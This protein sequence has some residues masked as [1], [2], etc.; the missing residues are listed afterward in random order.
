L[1]AIGLAGLRIRSEPY[2]RGLEKGFAL[3]YRR[4]GKGG[5]WL[6]RRRPDGGGYAEHKIGTSDD[7]QDAD[8]VAILDYGQAQRAA[9]AWWRS[10]LRRQEGHDTRSGPYTVADTIADYL[11][12]LE[13]RGG[14]S[15]Y[16]AQRAAE[17]HVLPALGATLTAK[18]IED[19]HRGLAA[20]PALARSKLGRKP[21]HRKADR[22]ADGIRKRRA[23]AN[24]PERSRPVVSFVR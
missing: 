6:A 18:R 9:R 1:R 19:W 21:N 22:S 20:K 10:E 16:H 2:W 17:T 23:T 5:T 12:E 24:R 4:R 7:L 13:G 8:G 3:G 14:K 15:V 11:T